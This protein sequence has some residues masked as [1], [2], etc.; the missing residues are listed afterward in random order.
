MFPAISPQST[1]DPGWG[2]RFCGFW[3][4]S[5]KITVSGAKSTMTVGKFFKAAS[6]CH[7]ETRQP[8]CQQ[9]A[10]AIAV[11]LPAILKKRLIF[12]CDGLDFLSIRL[13]G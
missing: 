10:P 9:R 12:P 11:G 2:N 1:F 8:T 6:L 4:S 5:T 3:Q 13:R 7:G